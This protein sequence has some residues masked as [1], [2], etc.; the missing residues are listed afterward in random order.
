MALIRD[1]LKKTDELIK[2]YGEKS[3]IFMQVGAFYEVYGVQNPETNAIHGSNIKHF[4]ELCEFLQ[5]YPILQTN[6]QNL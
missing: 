6:K 3:I 2:E 4:S 1:Y 5:Y